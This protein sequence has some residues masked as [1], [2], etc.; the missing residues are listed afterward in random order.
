MTETQRKFR[1]HI[2]AG[3]PPLTQEDRGAAEIEAGLN[4]YYDGT[5]FY[6]DNGK[7]FVPMDGRS[8]KSHI[9]LS[10]TF[11]PLE[12]EAT[13]CRI[14]TDRY[15]K[16]N[17]PLAGKMRGVY[18]SNG[19]LLL[20]STSPKIIQSRPG[21]FPT[22]KGFITDLFGGDDHAKDQVES[23]MGWL[24]NARRAML[25]G[26][27]RPGQALVLAGP[28][29]C[30]KTQII[31]Q[32]IVPTMGGRHSKPY[33]Y[34]SGKTGFNAEL[35]GAEVL[36]ID[37]EA[38]STRIEN[39]RALGDGIKT[40]LFASSVR[41]EGKFKA[42]FNFDP[43]WRIVIAV[44]DQPEAL[45]VLP[46]LSHDLSDKLMILKCWKALEL[47]DDDFE[48]WQATIAAELPAFLHYVEAFEIRP[49]NAD[50]R[51]GVKSFY[52]PDVVDAISELS[53]EHQLRTM[54]EAL[55][56][57][58]G[59]SL[60]WDGTSAAL[61]AILTAHSSPVRMDADRLL[62]SWPAACGVYLSRLVGK[63][64]E[65]LKLNDGDQQWR[66]SKSGEVD[67]KCEKSPP[68]PNP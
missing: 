49:E 61:K 64:V 65:K 29:A 60:P 54:I 34:L 22:I 13:V 50:G 37:D 7:D 32:V 39:R 11:T 24:A 9:K 36:V 63:G 10:G 47:S 48:I 38:A 58:G 57:S 62:G 59:I 31:K 5:K 41:I 6:L 23:F 8:I 53:P 16:H 33:K 44:N 67:T 35:I 17:G 43:L 14:Q 18:E 55:E 28:I 2:D 56:S 25:E 68:N 46:P 4:A 3:T 45:M 51:C 21:E 52:H 27:R 26:K 1:E 30:G 19:D 42:G 12:V 20:A 15:I 40:S 66:I